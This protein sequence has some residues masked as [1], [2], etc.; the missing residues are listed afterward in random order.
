MGT[1][2]KTCG[3]PERLFGVGTSMAGGT[4]ETKMRAPLYEQNITQ[5]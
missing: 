5:Q 2:I 1:T 4:G 3:W